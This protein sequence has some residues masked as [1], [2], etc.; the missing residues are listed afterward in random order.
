MICNQGKIIED[1]ETIGS[2]VISLNKDVIQQKGEIELVIE[3]N[4]SL[5]ADVN[6]VIDKFK[7]LRSNMKRI[8]QGINGK[9]QN[10]VLLFI[11]LPDI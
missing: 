8:G 6:G 7:S 1:I 9:M 10:L 4:E 2:N 3:K 11:V 5:Q